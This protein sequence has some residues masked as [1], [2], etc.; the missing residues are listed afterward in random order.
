MTICCDMT[1]P[2]II[3]ILAFKLNVCWSVCWNCVVL[4][5]TIVIPR[6]N[7]QL[8]IYRSQPFF[9]PGMGFYSF[10]NS[11]SSDRS[12]WGK[13]KQHLYLLTVGPF[14]RWHH[15]D[16][17]LLASE[18]HWLTAQHLCSALCGLSHCTQ[19]FPFSNRRR[20]LASF[21]NSYR[22]PWVRYEALSA[23]SQSGLHI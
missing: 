18:C 17:A 23:L 7:I 19:N 14:D 21:H 2:V 4:T 6:S 1:Q 11:Q 20:L 15:N 8:F 12:G 3:L 5:T 9:K 10:W 13:I 16:T 22:I